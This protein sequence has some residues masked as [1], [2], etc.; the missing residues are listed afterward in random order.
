LC[1]DFSLL[2]A[3]NTD[4]LDFCKA[5]NFFLKKEHFYSYSTGLQEI[6]KIARGMN[7]GKKYD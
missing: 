7:S 5:Y 1:N 4:C 3:K 6:I 2:G